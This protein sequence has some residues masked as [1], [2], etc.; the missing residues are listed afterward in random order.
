M[1]KKL[2]KRGVT[3]LITPNTEVHV[4]YSGEETLYLLAAFD[5]SGNKV[6]D[7]ILSDIVGAMPETFRL[8]ITV[9]MTLDEVLE[10]VT[11]RTI[12]NKEGWV[13]DFFGKLVKFKYET[14]IGRMVASKLSYKYIMRCLQNDRHEKMMSTLPEEIR[15]ISN[16]M[17]LEV[18]DKILECQEEASYAPLYD[19]HSQL[20]GGRDYFRTVCREFYREYASKIDLNNV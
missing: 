18:M 5:K 14:Y 6:H 2:V 3:E 17:T 8:P 19:L 20:D 10:N 13:V 9:S 16:I 11:D 12:E 4:D 7:S 1:T 15:E